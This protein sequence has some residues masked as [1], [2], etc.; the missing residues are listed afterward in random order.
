MIGLPGRWLSVLTGTSGSR[1]VPLGR[2]SGQA[3]ETLRKLFGGADYSLQS[4]AALNASIRRR[5]NSRS[6]AEGS[7]ARAAW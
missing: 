2:F 3:H 5:M 1:G 4:P 7:S 6:E